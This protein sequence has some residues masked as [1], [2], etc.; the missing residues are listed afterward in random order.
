MVFLYTRPVILRHTFSF[1]PP[2]VTSSGSNL[3]FISHVRLLF[4]CTMASHGH[5][6]DG[7]KG[8]D[9]DGPGCTDAACTHDHSHGHAHGHGHSHAHAPGVEVVPSLREQLK[10]E[11]QANNQATTDGATQ[12]SDERALAEQEARRLGLN[13]RQIANLTPAQVRKLATQARAA[14]NA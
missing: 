10:A 9:H 7:E 13:D 1:T 8:H 5:S 12:Q 11:Q 3:R 2:Y 6:H 4:S 14:T